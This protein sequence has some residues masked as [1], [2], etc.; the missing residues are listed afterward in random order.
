MQRQVTG[1]NAQGLANTAWSF[2]AVNWLDAQLTAVLAIEVQRRQIGFNAQELANARRDAETRPDRQC[3][4]PVDQ[5][6]LGIAAGG[7]R[8][9]KRKAEEET[10][11]AGSGNAA[12]AT[13]A[14]GSASGAAETEEG[15]SQRKKKKK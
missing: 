11:P 3:H 9:Q 10:A 15:V 12:T 8:G 13:A 2:A 1:L 5:G 6:P 7:L 4:V 14:G